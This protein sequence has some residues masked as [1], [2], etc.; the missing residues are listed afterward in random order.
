MCC[1]RL[2]L[3]FKRLIVGLLVT[4]TGLQRKQLLCCR[5]CN[6]CCGSCNTC[7]CICLSRVPCASLIA[8][9]VLALGFTGFALGLSEGV[10]NLNKW[11]KMDIVD[12]AS[13]GIMVLG[14]FFG[15]ISGLAL[16]HGFAATGR[17]RFNCC[18]G[19]KR[20]FVARCCIGMLFGWHYFMFFLWMFIAP[21]LIIPLIFM[22]IFFGVCQVK[23]VKQLG[24]TCI[25]FSDYGLDDIV[26]TEEVCGDELTVF[27][28]AMTGA[29]PYFAAAFVG[30]LFI[31]VG[32]FHMMFVL[33]AN[34]AHVHD[35]RTR[36]KA[37]E[38][39]T[40][41]KC[42]AVKDPDRYEECFPE[43]R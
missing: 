36:P 31:V 26:N 27:C 17:T 38:W 41:K 23:L 29:T 33:T 24:K 1:G 19:W 4:R 35:H 40:Y 9:F 43:P 37:S 13:L 21:I 28:E 6:A 15:S 12:L 5:Q 34:Y 10:A 3:A 18:G 32:M 20:R 7:C 11:L 42:C 14:I 16:F 39:S 30:G 8:S 2:W 25:K 22:G